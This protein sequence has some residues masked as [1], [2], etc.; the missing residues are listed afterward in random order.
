MQ[1]ISRSRFQSAAHYDA[2]GASFGFLSPAAQ[3]QKQ[4][5]AGARMRAPYC[6][7]LAYARGAYSLCAR[8]A[9]RSSRVFGGARAARVPYLCCVITT[10]MA[11]A[12]WQRSRT[13]A[14]AHIARASAA[15]ARCIRGCVSSRV[16]SP[17]LPC[18]RAPRSNWTEGLSSP[19]Q[20]VCAFRVQIS[21][22]AG[23][24]RMRR[25]GNHG[26][27]WRL[28]MRVALA[29]G[30]R[31]IWRL[32]LAARART[33]PPSRCAGA[34]CALARVSRSAQRIHHG[35]HSAPPLAYSCSGSALL[36]TRF[37][38]LLCLLLSHLSPSHSSLS[39]SHLTYLC[40]VPLWPLTW[41]MK[42]KGAGM[43]TPGP[44]QPGV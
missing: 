13:R 16:T 7:L 25:T 3:K 23:A 30:A 5:Y 44:F 8:I 18:L 36:W 31:L 40:L 29:A 6:I 20:F 33:P 37:A 32:Y 15:V 14:M 43:H 17:A 26:P 12:G 9:V 24:A 22:V 38:L 27:L 2:T 21:S 1:R 39:L 42:M 35:I 34:F 11:F 4:R 10:S 19:A 41:L 28:L